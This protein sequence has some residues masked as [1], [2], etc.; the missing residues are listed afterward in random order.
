MLHALAQKERVTLLF[1]ARDEVHNGAAVL[2]K[3]LLDL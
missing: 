2:R 3:F 1:G